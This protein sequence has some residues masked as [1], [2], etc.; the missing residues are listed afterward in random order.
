MTD[1]LALPS[2]LDFQL[3][4]HF[5]CQF[6]ECK[7]T[8]MDADFLIVFIILKSFLKINFQT[9]PFGVQVF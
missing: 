9:V 8:E 2:Q 7:I 1:G 4:F 3:G 6:L 5:H